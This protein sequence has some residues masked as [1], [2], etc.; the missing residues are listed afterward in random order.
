M[1]I[2]TTIHKAN[3]KLFKLA[4]GEIALA[5]EFFNAHLPLHIRE[6]I[7]LTTL[8][9]ENHSFIDPAYK[10]TEADVVYSVKLQQSTAYIYTLVEQ[11][12]TV[13]AMLA[14]RLWVYMVRIMELHLKQHPG[15]PLPLVLPIVLY[16]GEEV[17]D[18]PLDI[19]P[20]FG[21]SATLARETLL[22]S[23][24]LIDVNR[25]DDD[26]LREQMLSGL[27]AF[28]L[29]YRKRTNFKRFLETLLPWVQE[30][31][32]QGRHGAFLSRMV[33]KY[34]IAATQQGD[35]D[36]LVQEAQHY[37]SSELR[38]EI[39]TIAEQWQQEGLQK[40]MQ[41]GEATVLMRQ[42]GRRFGNIPQRLV[43]QITQAD[44]ET[45][46]VWSD[47]VLDAASLE[48]IFVKTD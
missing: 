47:K 37:L 8:H 1:T 27:V 25:I 44:T 41:Q 31:E 18:A 11:Q 24:Q 20:L 19:F 42:I 5:K 15:S 30:V 39:M 32:I 40:G 21:E 28:T 22:Q 2:S 3:D 16:A 35:K 45:L 48:E 13:D 14:F 29:K 26:I 46:L 6:K 4:M 23:Y 12:S 36:L 34:V 9:L 33:L 43:Q 7:D 17:W 10:E 38:G